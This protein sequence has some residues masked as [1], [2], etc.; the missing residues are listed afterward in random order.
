MSGGGLINHGFIR[1]KFTLGI[2]QICVFDVESIISRAY[3]SCFRSL[4]PNKIIGSNLIIADGYLGGKPLIKL[5]RIKTVSD[6]DDI[7][8]YCERS[9]AGKLDSGTIPVSYTHLDV[10]KRQ[11]WAQ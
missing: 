1:Y 11:I 9:T 10:Y 2:G 3:R 7:V 4:I 8:S 6:V 5:E